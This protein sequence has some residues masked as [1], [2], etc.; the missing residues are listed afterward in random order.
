MLS[1]SLLL[2]RIHI[3]NNT[4]PNQG[5]HCFSF[6][7]FSWIKGYL[8]ISF[9]VVINARIPLDRLQKQSLLLANNPEIVW[10]QGTLPIGCALQGSFL[11]FGML[12]TTR[13]LLCESS[14]Q[15]NLTALQER[16]TLRTCPRLLT[17]QTVAWW[18]WKISCL[19]VKMD[20]T[21]RLKHE[22]P[23][24]GNKMWIWLVI[25]APVYLLRHMTERF[26]VTSSQRVLSGGPTSTFF[27][28]TS[29]QRA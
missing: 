5:T 22:Q 24:E 26:W 28:R 23:L 6:L 16:G 18:F 15:E 29:K 4:N 9:K 19:H 21:K 17:Y 11:L 10:F 14:Y 27:T 13:G 25:R 20:I 3:Q 1:S 8:N 12:L 7:F 2:P